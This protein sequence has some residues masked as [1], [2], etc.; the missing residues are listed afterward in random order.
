ME[1]EWTINKIN[2]GKGCEMELNG[3]C[4]FHLDECHHEFIEAIVKMLNGRTATIQKAW[5]E[6]DALR[7]KLS[8]KTKFENLVIKLFDE[9][10]FSNGC[11]KTCF[12]CKNEAWDENTGEMYCE[13]EDTNCLTRQIVKYIEELKKQRASPEGDND[14]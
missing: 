8:K 13:E 5:K 2:N 6:I 12:N 10:A 7:A 11:C 9:I 14:G 4:V 1:N 3:I